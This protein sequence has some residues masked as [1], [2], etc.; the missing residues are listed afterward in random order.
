[1]TRNHSRQ[2]TI[3][4]LCILCA[5]FTQAQV[6]TISSGGDIIGSGGSVAFSLGQVVYT[7]NTGITGS[8]AQGIQ[9]AYEIYSYGITEN[10]L[11]ISL[12]TFP[13]P[14]TDLLTLQIG[15]YNGERLSYHLYDLQGILL[16]NAQINA[17]QTQID[18]SALPSAT[19][20]IK[21][22][23]QENQKVQSFKIIKK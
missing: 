21:I 12:I 11:N 8:I 1:M 9:N 15:N 23:N 17:A 14:S 19:Y 2:L 5:G 10:A 16:N 13:N 22:Q 6:A 7:S 4:S 3:L 18:I 20:L